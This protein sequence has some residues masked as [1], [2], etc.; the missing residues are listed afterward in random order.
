[1][2][3][4]SICNNDTSYREYKAEETIGIARN[5]HEDEPKYWDFVGFYPQPKDLKTVEFNIMGNSTSSSEVF[6]SKKNAEDEASIQSNVIME[7]AGKGY[8]INFGTKSIASQDFEQAKLRVYSDY[9]Y[10]EIHPFRTESG[11][12]LSCGND[13]IT[14]TIGSVHKDVYM[15][16]PVE[17]T[18]E[19]KTIDDKTIKFKVVGIDQCDGTRI[20][21]GRVK[22][23]F[24]FPY[25]DYSS[26][27]KSLGEERTVERRGDLSLSAE[28]MGA[29]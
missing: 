6:T 9:R 7:E 24:D 8:T 18:L 19:G 5:Y 12:V 21:S 2:L 27:S 15:R 20:T 4:R 25:T 28:Y 22:L 26:D 14:E 17:L 16:H 1:V 11:T 13:H 3:F 29:S 23:N 10:I